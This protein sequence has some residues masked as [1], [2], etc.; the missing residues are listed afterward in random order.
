MEEIHIKIGENNLF[1]T[2]TYFKEEE[3]VGFPERFEINSIECKEKDLYEL[4]EWVSSR[5]TDYL[6]IIEELV[7]EN[8]E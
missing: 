5:K 4:L 1:I 8:R 7:L 2:G 3:E 6:R